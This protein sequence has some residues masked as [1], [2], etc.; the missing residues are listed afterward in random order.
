[1]KSYLSDFDN[2]RLI[3]Q[4][5]DYNLASILLFTIISMSQPTWIVND[6]RLLAG[7]WEFYYG[8][9]LASLV[10]LGAYRDAT[11]ESKR[12]SS[13]LVFDNAKTNKFKKGTEFSF[14][15]KL[16]EID[17]DTLASINDGWIAKTS[18]AGT[19]VTGATQVL[20]S[21]S[22]Q[23]LT[24]IEIEHQNFDFSAVTITSIVGSVNGTI[25]VADYLQVIWPGGKRNIYF[26][27]WGTVTTLTQTFTI[28]YDY[29]P[30]QSRKF[31][32]AET[33][34]A[35]K[36]YARFIHERS[37]G[38][39]IT[40]DLKEVQNLTW[41]TIDFVGNSDDDVATIDVELNGKVV[42]DGFVYEL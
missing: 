27:S 11:I 1:M 3:F 38:K 15:F 8:T 14:K 42:Q 16:A 13:E 2:N 32:F 41:L 28:T 18:V 30:A 17:P 5:A 21:W 24:M 33:G 40:I 26:K 22:V 39:Q 6:Q 9:S 25:A 37:N 7:A 4:K 20:A 29:T 19:L 12:E 10:R 23:Y 31:T 34:I 35:T 36:F